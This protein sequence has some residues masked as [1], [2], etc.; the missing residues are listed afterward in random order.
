MPKTWGARG[1]RWCSDAA[2]IVLGDARGALRVV[3]SSN[4]DA[5]L[6][7][8]LQLQSDERPVPGL[9]PHRPL[10][11]VVDQAEAARQ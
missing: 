5:Q 1:T 4:E 10:V 9:L 6:M 8:L 3:A 7:E 2:G 11:S